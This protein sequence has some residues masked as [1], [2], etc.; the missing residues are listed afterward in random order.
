VDFTL[1]ARPGDI[2]LSSVDAV[3]ISNLK[4]CAPQHHQLQPL[5]APSTVSQYKQE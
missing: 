4:N 2:I 5:M 1:E 3:F